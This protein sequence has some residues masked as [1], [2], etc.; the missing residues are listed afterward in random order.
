MATPKIIYFPLKGRAQIPFL[1]A[2]YAEKPIEW[3]KEFD[4]P[5]LKPTTHFGQLP[6]LEDGDLKINQSMAIARYLGRKYGLE[7]DTDADFA[8]SEQLIEETVDIFHD[9]VKLFGA[10]DKAAAFET[11]LGTDVPKHFT[12]LEA[13]LPAGSNSFGSKITTGDIA[14]FG[15]INIILD[16]D[17]TA[18]DA[19]PKLKAFY[20]NLAQ[21]PG[22]KTFIEQDLPLPSALKRE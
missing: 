11:L 19:F 7:G 16:I 14:L 17:A 21:H 20:A 5:T 4:W 8:I 1:V 9:F 10:A 12:H 15:T 18:L 22:V 6:Q 3:V 2:A 13:F